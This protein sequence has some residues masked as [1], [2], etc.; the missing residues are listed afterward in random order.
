MSRT[1]PLERYLLTLDDESFFAVMRNYLGP[2]RTPFNKSELVSRLEEFLRRE[3]TRERIIAMLT[4]EDLQVLSAVA[5]LGAPSRD[6]LARFLGENRAETLALIVNLRDRLLL[7]EN[8][9]R[10]RIEVNPVLRGHLGPELLGPRHVVEGAAT[11]PAVEP[12]RPPW[13]STACAAALLSFLRIVP[14][15]YTR[16]GDL[17]RKAQVALEERFGDLFLGDAGRARLDE[18]LAA[19]ENLGL[20]VRGDSSVR[21]NTNAWELLAEL[22]DR[23][24]TAI[25]WLSPLTGSID[26]IFAYARLFLN[27]YAV[28]PP[29]RAYTPVEVVRL[30]YIVRPRDELPIDEETVRRLLHVGVFLPEGPEGERVRINRTVPAL[31]E[32]SSRRSPPVVHGN[33]EILVPPDSS[34]ASAV[35]VARMADLVRYDTAPRYLLTRESLRAANR[36]R[37]D[38]PLE[39]LSRETDG[40]V[41]QNVRFLVNRW[42]ARARAVRLLDAAV[43]IAGDEEARVLADYPDFMD[44]VREHPAPTVFILHRSRINRVR[45]ILVRLGLEDVLSVETEPEERLPIPEYDVL[46]RRESQP[47]LTDRVGSDLSTILR[48]QDNTAPARPTHSDLRMELHQTLSTLHIDED[49]RRELALRIDRG[50]ILFPEQLHGEIR[51]THATEARGLDYLGKIR[52]IEQAL[53]RNDMLEIIMRDSHDPERILVRPREIAQTGDDLMLRAVR[54]SD[55]AAIKIRIRRISLLRRLSGTL[56]R[57]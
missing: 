31:L 20:V 28:L 39:H 33:M 29:D 7:V 34:F 51:S 19:L 21:L 41:P 47:M 22:P 5:L 8:D 52:L 14:D 48:A 37:L 25:V 49:N 16:S 42:S 32:E 56:I 6:Q 11:E 53:E 38:D 46:F 15:L 35:T 13:W 23:W 17:R 4:E 24:V 12:D 55:G 27:V 45:E 50:L 2:I 57:M 26:R 3:E 10:S 44:Q 36:D 40:G 9:G 1:D 30:F 43:L 18:V 54:E